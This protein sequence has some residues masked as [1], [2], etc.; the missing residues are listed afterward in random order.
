MK[1]ECNKFKEIIPLGAGNDLLGAELD[2]LRAHLSEC[3]ECRDEFAAYQALKE[4]VGHLGG[5]KLP[6]NEDFWSNQRGKIMQAV[7]SR[8]VYTDSVA[9]VM[10]RYAA[11]LLA[12]IISGL[13]LWQ[14][15]KPCPPQTGNELPVSQSWS[16]NF[17]G[18]ELAP[19]TKPVANHLGI[20][21]DDGLI[22]SCLPDS[23]PAQQ[24]GLRMGDIVVEVNG[25]SVT[26]TMPGGL[27]GSMDI[28]II[29]NGNKIVIRNK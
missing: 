20:A 25:Y 10:F 2:N 15:V 7:N 28:K 13:V 12:G 6:L 18:A 14:W 21:P 26:S 22:I 27:T 24:L 29:R 4:S 5:E 3:A 17:L 9:Q 23:S 11:M 1:K 16:N 19:L 8:P